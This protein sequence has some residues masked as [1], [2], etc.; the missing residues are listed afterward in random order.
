[1]AEKKLSRSS[2]D[3]YIETI[4]K[5]TPQ[6]RT[7][8]S[9]ISGEQTTQRTNFANNDASE[10]VPVTA[11]AIKSKKTS[12]TTKSG[13]P[14][15]KKTTLG[16]TEHPQIM[17]A[18]TNGGKIVYGTVK[19]GKLEVQGTVG[20]INQD[21][22]GVE[23]VNAGKKSTKSKPRRMKGGMHKVEIDTDGMR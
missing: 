8:L 16:L 21:L 17:Q 23:S 19:D 14:V 5:L 12:K 3:D 4:N 20:E 6:L 7:I 15:R 11:G 1:M 18:V 13:V 22:L 10:S 2:Y 9:H